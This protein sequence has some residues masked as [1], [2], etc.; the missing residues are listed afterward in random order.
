[1]VS[2]TPRSTLPPSSPVR[3]S[4]SLSQ[5]TDTAEKPLL[6]HPPHDPLGLFQPHFSPETSFPRP[7]SGSPMSSCVW[8]FTTLPTT[9]SP[10]FALSFFQ[11]ES[12]F[13]VHRKHSY[14]VLVSLSTPR[15]LALLDGFNIHW[16]SPD[17]HCSFSPQPKGTFLHSTVGV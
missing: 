15:L 11:F 7:C 5:C 12:A 8:R 13:H 4:D 6:T 1:M 17:G 14:Q 9:F 10:S 3:N 2:Q 16:V